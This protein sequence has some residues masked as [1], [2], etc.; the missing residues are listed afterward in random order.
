MERLFVSVT[1][2]YTL[3]SCG[4]LQA[5]FFNFRSQPHRYL[6]VGFWTICSHVVY[7]LIWVVWGDQGK[8]EIPVP[9][10][11]AYPIL[12]YLFARAYYLPKGAVSFRWTA[13]MAVPLFIHFILFTVALLQ[14]KENSWIADYSKIYY[15]SCM[16]SLLGYATLTARLYSSSKS[17]STPTDILIRQLTMFCFGLVV[18]TYIVLYET[19]VGKS[20]IGFEVRPM[21]YL[22]L[23]LGF[24]LIIRYI[25]AN[26]IHMF[27]SFSNTAPE[28]YPENGKRDGKMTA[29]QAQMESELVAEIIEK[30]LNRTKLYLNPSVSLDMLARQTSIP[31][32]QLT[33]V[34]SGYYKK[35]FYRFIATTRIK[36]AINR[37]LETGDTVTLDSFSYECGFNSKTS[38]NRYFKEYTGMTPSEYRCAQRTMCDQAV[39]IE[40]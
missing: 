38:F 11:L 24:A 16:L 32:H 13:L 37:M 22:F 15:I 27:G 26:N 21:V 34:F 14:P 2:I 17:P 7:K 40:Q 30:E 20:D 10:G 39:C 8:Y 1:L 35:S 33:Q 28:A 19:S 5:A 25:V 31:R 9:F 18:L 23:V 6:L 4:F 3:L 36:Y 12:L 29:S